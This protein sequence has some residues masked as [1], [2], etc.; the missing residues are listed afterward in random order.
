MILHRLS[1]ERN[2]LIEAIKEI[3]V[4]EYAL[5]MVEKGLPLNVLVKDVK[6][7]AANILKQEAIAIVHI[8]RSA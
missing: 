5:R 7:P 1:A 6:S 2:R 8:N 4:D 3:G